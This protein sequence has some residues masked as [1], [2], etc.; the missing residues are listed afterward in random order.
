MNIIQ[1]CVVGRKRL[2]SLEHE[3]EKNVGGTEKTSGPN[4]PSLGTVPAG[5]PQS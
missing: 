3:T 4:G 1:E 5:S 2:E